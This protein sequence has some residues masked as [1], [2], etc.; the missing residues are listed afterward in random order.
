MTKIVLLLNF[1]NV[2]IAKTHLSHKAALGK[3]PL[4]SEVLGNISSR[5]LMCNKIT[6]K[7]FLQWALWD[8]SLKKNGEELGFRGAFLY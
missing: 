5:L 6:I 2:G 1:D 3:H 8:Y 4:K 7:K